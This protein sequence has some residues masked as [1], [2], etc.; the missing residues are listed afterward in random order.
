MS[1][2]KVKTGRIKFFNKIKGFGFIAPVNDDRPEAEVFLHHTLLSKDEETLMT[3]GTLVQYNDRV[4]DDGR[5]RAVSCRVSDQFTV[6]PLFDH[7]SEWQFAVMDKLTQQ[8]D[9]L[10]SREE[11]IDWLAD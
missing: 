9:L 1:R 11:L 2:T 10:R 3:P 5:R 8:T 7:D 6:I 4:S